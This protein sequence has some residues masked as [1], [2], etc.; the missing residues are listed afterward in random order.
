MY[1]LLNERLDSRGLSVVELPETPKK[2]N[3]LARQNS[4]GRRKR[5]STIDVCDSTVTVTR[6]IDTEERRSFSPGMWSQ[7]KL[8]CKLCG[9]S[10]RDKNHIMNGCEM[11]PN[12][13]V[14]VRKSRKSRKIARL[15]EIG[16]YIDPGD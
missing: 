13:A 5:A 2:R 14:D 9:K 8:L 4:I 12:D 1:D 3:R 16:E 10:T 7:W 15:V 11:L 6:T